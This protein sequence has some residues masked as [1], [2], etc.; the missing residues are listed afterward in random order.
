[1]EY[2]ILEFGFWILDCGAPRLNT[3]TTSTEKPVLDVGFWI[4]ALR[5]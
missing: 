5:A 1:M 4:A 3:A 2:P